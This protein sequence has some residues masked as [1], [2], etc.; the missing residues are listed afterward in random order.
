MIMKTVPQPPLLK[1][2]ILEAKTK[3]A[4]VNPSPKQ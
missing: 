4:A 3:I 1:D 2:I